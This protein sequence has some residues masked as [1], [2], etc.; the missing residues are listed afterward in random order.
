MAQRGAKTRFRD[1]NGLQRGLMAVAIVSILLAVV[2]IVL[3]I[4]VIVVSGSF[5]AASLEAFE[6]SGAADL[7]AD[8]AR[9]N[10]DFDISQFLGLLARIAAYL[11]FVGIALMVCGA[12]G[13]YCARRNGRLLRLSRL[14]VVGIAI[15]TAGLLW[16]PWSTVSFEWFLPFLLSLGILL[17]MQYIASRLRKEATGEAAEELARDEAHK[18]MTREERLSDDSRLGF[19]RVI[20][21]AYLLNMVFMIAG[22]VFTTRNNI[23]YDFTQLFDWANLVFVGVS[24]YMIYRR[25]RITRQWVITFS[26]IK[27]VL[28]AVHMLVIGGLSGSNIIA[29]L[30]LTLWDIVVAIYFWHSDRVRLIMTEE[31]STEANN[32]SLEFDRRSPIFWRN[33]L[34]YYC[35]FST[36]GHWMEAGFC[37]L[38]SLGLFEGD[39]DFNNTM[40]FRDWL[41]PFP[42]HGIAVVLIALILWPLKEWFRKRLNPILTLIVS[43]FF[44]MLFCTGIEFVG[45]IMFNRNLQLWNYS[46][47]PFNFMGQVCLQ[48]AVGFGLA[49]TLIVYL[50][51]PTLER[52]IAKVPND[53]MNTVCVGVFAFYAILTALYVID[54][55]PEAAA[56]NAK[57]IRI[58]L[59]ARA[60]LPIVR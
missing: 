2:Y 24:F 28:N 34:L 48:N 32:E 25:L 6:E 45:G 35:I 52:L 42:M 49:A 23:S 43:F 18:H 15:T 8:A 17:G 58:A 4:G 30:F 40:L 21:V 53:V 50:V 27:I 57:M 5:V 56:A 55:S 26:L 3:S 12:Y 19:L 39:I 38:V 51:Y 41:Y 29:I 54:L 16:T 59:D 36:L 46:D 22:L 11:S 10:P 33:M 20:Q 13:L 31:I 1:M 47:I 37:Y 44:N 60:R 7:V 9:E 14:I